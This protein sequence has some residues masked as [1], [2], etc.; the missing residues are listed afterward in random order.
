MESIKLDGDKA[1]QLF[2]LHEGA[3]AF[4]ALLYS[5]LL[6]AHNSS[7]A[8]SSATASPF[9]SIAPLL[10]TPPVPTSLL[11]TVISSEVNDQLLLDPDIATFRMKAGQRSNHIEV[12]I[13]LT[14]H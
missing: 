13:I 11:N 10:Y 8:S 12:V 7:T 2:S 9:D 14:C 1:K 4:R 5:L 6:S 3:A